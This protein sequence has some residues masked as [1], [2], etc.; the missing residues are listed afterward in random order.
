MHYLY[1]ALTVLT[2]SLFLPSTA[3]AATKLPAATEGF[4]TQQQVEQRVREYFKDAPE[5]IEIARCESKF[6][7]FTDAGNVLRGGSSGGMVGVFQFFESIHAPAATTLGLDLTTLEGNLAYAK[8]IYTTQGTTPW[9]S[10]KSCW[11]VKP[12]TAATVTTRDRAAL[13]VQIKQLS[14]LILQ[15]QKRLAAQKK[16][17]RR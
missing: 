10:A 8:H 9:D 7:Q 12:L 2:S 11:D 16:T 14:E 4:Q 17:Q 1:I 15:L 13:Y 5:M 3:A 6:R